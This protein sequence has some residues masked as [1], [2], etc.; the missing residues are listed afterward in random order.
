MY[1]SHVKNRILYN[2]YYLVVNRRGKRSFPE[3]HVKDGHLIYT[4]N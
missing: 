1:V 3:L 2:Y 4:N